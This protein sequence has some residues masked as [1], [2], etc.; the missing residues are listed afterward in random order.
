MREGATANT[1]AGLWTPESEKS[2]AGRSWGPRSVRNQPLPKATSVTASGGGDPK[3]LLGV[4][5]VLKAAAAPIIGNPET[6]V[7]E[8]GQLAGA[9]MAPF[10]KA[11]LLLPLGNPPSGF[12]T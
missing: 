5:R 10:P 12:K 7:A 8:E 4:V 11:I 6:E 2:Q 3:T 9:V 1:L